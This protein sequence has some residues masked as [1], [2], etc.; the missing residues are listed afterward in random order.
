MR[1]PSAS[2]NHYLGLVSNRGVCVLCA[3]RAH[4]VQ[5]CVDF[6]L[7]A[8]ELMPKEAGEFSFACPMGMFRGRLIVE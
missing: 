6:K 2:V 8:V 5:N 3:L 7:V 1:H 4:L